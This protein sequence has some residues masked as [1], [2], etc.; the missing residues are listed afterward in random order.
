MRQHEGPAHLPASW[1]A[2]QFC[3]S[4]SDL[5][6]WL[7]GPTVQKATAFNLIFIS[8]FI[9]GHTVQ[10]VELPGPGGQGSNPAPCNGSWHLN[11]WTTR[12][13]AATFSAV[14]LEKKER[15]VCSCYWARGMSGLRQV[16]L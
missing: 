6:K 11:L 12:K 4:Y 9:S 16:L 8:L 3:Q 5:L 1:D 15:A 13:S 14:S 10:R 7:V 2:Q